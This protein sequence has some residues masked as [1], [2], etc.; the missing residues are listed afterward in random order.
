MVCILR[1]NFTGDV[2]INFGSGSSTCPAFTDKSEPGTDMKP[3][4]KLRLN[5]A[6]EFRV[7]IGQNGGKRGYESITGMHCRVF[8]WVGGEGNFK[9]AHTIDFIDLRKC[10]MQKSIEEKSSF[11]NSSS[12]QLLFSMCVDSFIYRTIFLHGGTST[13][14]YSW[15]SVIVFVQIF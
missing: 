4:P 2:K 14:I 9:K 10:E 1:V 15:N 12:V 8:E 13:S 5:N 11:S 3:W 6:Q 7:E